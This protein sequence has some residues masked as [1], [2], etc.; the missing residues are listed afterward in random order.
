MKEPKVVDLDR[1]RAEANEEVIFASVGV[2]SY[3]RLGKTRAVGTVAICNDLTYAS[4]YVPER[5]KDR[6]ALIGALDELK[7]KIMEA[8]TGFLEI[9][10]KD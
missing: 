10:R 9:I 6:L 2:H 5:R 8:D 7:A 3:A 1:E 4:A